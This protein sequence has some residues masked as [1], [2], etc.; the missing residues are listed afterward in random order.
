[1]SNGSYVGHVQTHTLS[2]LETNKVLRNTYMLLALSLLFSAAMAGL[3][4]WVKAPYM[5]PWITLGGFF[6]LQF[7]ISRFRDSGV[8]VA[9]IFA[10]TGF[11]GFTLGPVLSYFM[12]TP[13]GGNIVM[14]AMATTGGVFL[15]LSAY[16]LKS[17]KDFNYMGGFLFAGIWVAFFAGIAA[18][19][20]HMPTLSVAVSGA[21]SLISCGYILFDTSR[22]IHGGETNYILA[23]NALFVDIYNLFVSLLNILGIMR[24]DD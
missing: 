23:T 18:L 13:G 21:F 1:M 14:M 22:I 16:V 9:L 3:S 11:M 5:G 2:V 10:L 17:R 24:S 15:A 12:R 6:V 4:M 7:L 8:G 20:F 19:I